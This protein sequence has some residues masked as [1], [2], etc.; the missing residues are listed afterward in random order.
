MIC[1]YLGFA[2]LISVIATSCGS[3][4][5]GTAHTKDEDY[6]EYSRAYSPD[7]MMLLIDYASH[8]GP[9]DYEI[10][11][12]AIIKAKDTA[13]NLAVHTLPKVL[14]NLKWIDNKTVTA[15]YDVIPSIRKGQKVTMRDTTVNGV[16]V[17]VVFQDYIGKGAQQKVL[18]RETSPDGKRE[19][20]AY[21]YSNGNDSGFIHLSIIPAH[22]AI[23]KYGNYFI[24]NPQADYIYYARWSSK[25]E[26]ILFT[27]NTG[28]DLIYYG[29]VKTR[30]EIN[31]QIVADD[32]RYA[33]KKVWQGK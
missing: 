30:P 16:L 13:G 1:K 3:D 12:T 2:T 7:N 21:R 28:K 27:N 10:S 18:Y 14:S 29:L 6:I 9:F 20:V 17:K 19:L 33:K 32:Y 11:G 22:A 24:A 31:Y 4:R 26:L 15:M 5:A 25:N 23:P 8:K